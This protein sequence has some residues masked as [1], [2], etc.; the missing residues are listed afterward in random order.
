MSAAEK[1]VAGYDLATQPP[2][3][4]Q[5]SLPPLSPRPEPPLR[6]PPQPLSDSPPARDPSAVA[7]GDYMSPSIARVEL[8]PSQADSS[9]PD[10]FSPSASR[11]PIRPSYR[12]PSTARFEPEPIVRV[13]VPL[14][15]LPNNR[16]SPE[17]SPARLSSSA[18]VCD[19][20]GRA[21]LTLVTEL[22]GTVL[23]RLDDQMG[24][25][26]DVVGCSFQVPH[27][28]T[29]EDDTFSVRVS[30]PS[31]SAQQSHPRKS[32][33]S[34]TTSR[35]PSHTSSRGRPR[36]TRFEDLASKRSLSSIDTAQVPPSR[37]P[38]VRLGGRQVVPDQPPPYPSDS[39]GDLPLHRHTHGT[40]DLPLLLEGGDLIASA[41]AIAE[42]LALPGSIRDQLMGHIEGS[43]AERIAQLDEELG[44]VKRARLAATQESAKWK[45]LAS[46]HKSR[47]GDL[48]RDLEVAVERAEKYY[49]AHRSA[50]EAHTSAQKRAV[51]A[52]N[53]LRA[54]LEE[55]E[56]RVEEIGR[57]RDATQRDAGEIVALKEELTAMHQRL[58]ALRA[59]TYEEGNLGDH[60][61]GFSP[62]RRRDMLELHVALQQQN[63]EL[64]DANRRLLRGSEGRSSDQCEI[65]QIT[66]VGG[67]S[68]VPHTRSASPTSATNI[69]L[70]SPVALEESEAYT[71]GALLEMNAHWRDALLELRRDF[72]RTLILLDLH[73][74]GS[75]SPSRDSLEEL[76]TLRRQHQEEIAA[77]D[78][79]SQSEIGALKSLLEAA[80]TTTPP[81]TLD[82][83]VARLK[84]VVATLEAKL[85]STHRR[86]EAVQRAVSSF[87]QDNPDADVP[88]SIVV[89][90]LKGENE[91][92][93]SV[94]K[95][96]SKKDRAGKGE[97]TPAKA[98][99]ESPPVPALEPRSQSTGTYEGKSL[100]ELAHTDPPPPPPAKVTASPPPHHLTKRDMVTDT[101]E[102]ARSRLNVLEDALISHL[103]DERRREVEAAS[104]STPHRS[105]YTSIPPRHRNAPETSREIS[106]SRYG[107]FT[108]P[109]HLQPSPARRPS[110]ISRGVS[111]SPSSQRDRIDRHRQDFSSASLERNAVER[112]L[113]SEM[114]RWHSVILS[115]H[116]PK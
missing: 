15:S 26:D 104:A 89:D 58:A 39:F 94:I 114:E 27:T 100:E 47:I 51:R 57:F 97:K 43:Y 73:R 22:A 68:Y 103:S 95:A 53:Q 87:Q 44:E 29:F 98:I 30:S 24:C 33:S 65:E 76:Q 75:A 71:R 83:E 54:V 110:S 91:R 50:A 1:V 106:S 34:L 108:T 61:R 63:K 48:E 42:T 92:L 4:P 25:L 52:E 84:G 6:L 45:S 78:A 105:L 81:S 41:R 69:V 79:K 102:F 70:I 88:A 116:T 13:S 20:V 93:V 60:E 46:K 17:P 7:R 80:H 36:T 66:V 32:L 107:V 40:G 56:A 35:G 18:E 82:P 28:D 115:T 74:T 31:T 16:V 49:A 59:V 14:L 101:L 55:Q 2:G 111:G 38:S 112:G 19:D 37:S 99:P 21:L 11:V 90:A 3:T 96:L 85:M 12:E 86:E 5:S 109:P 23:D 9:S 72:M 10:A 77:M 64:L 62:Y 8:S 113:R 67:P